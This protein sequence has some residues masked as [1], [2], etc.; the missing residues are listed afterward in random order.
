MSNFF[1]SADDLKR[2]FGIEARSEYIEFI[3]YEKDIGFSVKRTYPKESRFKP[4]VKKN[5]EP[6]TY[7][8]ISILY[9]TDRCSSSKPMVVPISAKIS[10]F[11]KF[12]YEHWDY[13]FS[14]EDCPIE[15]SVIASKK[16]PR[17]V[18]LSAFDQYVYDHNNDEFLDAEGQRLEGISIID[19]LYENHLATV[20]QFKGLVFRWKLASRNKTGALCETF[21][22]ILKW[23]LNLA[24][25]L[26]RPCI[27]NSISMVN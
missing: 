1:T 19:G 20:D 22:G 24:D 11:N 21:S 27:T 14:N 2:A 5:G 15:E 26:S 16:T 17:P 10:V 3:P 4:P 8:L 6:D 9:E 12:V 7:A 23:L 25:K 13:D 18:D